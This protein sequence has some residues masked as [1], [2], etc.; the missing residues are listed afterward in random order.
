ME[1]YLTLKFFSIDSK[2]PDIKCDSVRLP[3]SDNAKGEFSG[4]YGIKKGHAKAVFS[5][6]EGKV[7]AWVEA[8]QI[9]SANIS[10]GFAMVENNEV[11]I[12]VDSV[13]EYKLIE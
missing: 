9:F 7:T 2:I 10:T 11:R 4:S 3:V 6:K 13:E 8:E 1:N 5:L 12:T